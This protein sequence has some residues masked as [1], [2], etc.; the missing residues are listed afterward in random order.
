MSRLIK[1]A[2]EDASAFGA[3]PFYLFLIFLF[4]ILGE[5]QLGLWLLVGFILSFA[6]III[7]KLFYFKERPK[8]KEYKNIFEKIEASSF[9]SLHSWR[10]IMILIFLSYYYKSI[11]LGL[12]LG[13]ICVIVIFS[14]KYLMKHYWVDIIFGALFGLLMSLFIIWWI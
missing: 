14:R 4:F 8:K 6:V 10:I 2:I 12:L 1:E 7:I 3:L 11:Y 13:V 9:P 5:I